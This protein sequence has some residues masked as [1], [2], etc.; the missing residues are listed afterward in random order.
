M[1]KG[2]FNKPPKKGRKTNTGKIPNNVGFPSGH[3]SG[4]GVIRK[5]TVAELEAQKKLGMFVIVGGKPF[6]GV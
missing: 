4:G 3:V 5:L 2:A 6:Y 1:N